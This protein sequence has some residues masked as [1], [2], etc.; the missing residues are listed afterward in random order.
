M[1]V[2]TAI[3]KALQKSTHAADDN[4]VPFAAQT[5]ARVAHKKRARVKPKR[6]KR[7]TDRGRGDGDFAGKAGKYEDGFKKVKING[8]TYMQRDDGALFALQP[9]G[10]W[11]LV[12]TPGSKG[13][14]LTPWL[15][16]AGALGAGAAGGAYLASESS[17]RK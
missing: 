5:P 8:K 10:S 7:I 16:G 14:S 15:I 12:R 6:Y 1:S 4:V 2:R 3:L 9:D 17:R 11:R 13:G